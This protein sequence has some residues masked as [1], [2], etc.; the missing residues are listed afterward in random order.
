[1]S[2]APHNVSSFRKGRC[3]VISPDVAEVNGEDG[4]GGAALGSSLSYLLERVVHSSSCLKTSKR[5]ATYFA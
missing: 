3:L 1:M 2:W 4:V 5:Q